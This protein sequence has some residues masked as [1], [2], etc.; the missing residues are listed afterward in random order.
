MAAISL[1]GPGPVTELY[2]P[3]AVLNATFYPTP[4]TTMAERLE[5]FTD[6]TANKN[7][8]AVVDESYVKA[9]GPDAGKIDGV[10][11]FSYEDE[12][13]KTRT[14]KARFTFIFEREPGGEWL[15]VSHHSSQCPE[16]KYNPS[17]LTAPSL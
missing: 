9:L 10:Y 14:V 16:P 13:D 5:Y 7:L 6:F 8:R 17:S 15:I 4:V 12:D 11:T 2:E 1:G 3:D